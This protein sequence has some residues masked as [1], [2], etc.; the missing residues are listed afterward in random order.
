MP[1]SALHL[2]SS[3]SR[4]TLMRVCGESD[5]R[6]AQ[7]PTLGL[8]W[9]PKGAPV[10]PG[11]PLDSQGC[12]CASKG[13]EFPVGPLSYE[14]TCIP[15]TGTQQKVDGNSA[16]TVSAENRRASRL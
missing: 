14:V 12:P 9:F 10:F 6:L 2:S 4:W 15:P 7:V 13:P 1:L 11:V 3:G 5:A 16:Y 8:A